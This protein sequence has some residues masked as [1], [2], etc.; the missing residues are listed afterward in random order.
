MVGGISAR[1]NGTYAQHTSSVSINKGTTL[2]SHSARQ[3]NTG[4][5]AGATG[6]G[7]AYISFAIR[8][9]YASLNENDSITVSTSVSGD[10]AKVNPSCAIYKIL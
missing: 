4:T 6:T 5:G 3:G 2:F 8:V 7:Y 1:S 10:G 9:N